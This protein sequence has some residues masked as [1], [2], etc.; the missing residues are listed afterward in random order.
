MQCNPH[1]V[2][3]EV[4]VTS[5]ANKLLRENIAAVCSSFGLLL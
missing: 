2:D 1:R 5:L 4:N 3:R